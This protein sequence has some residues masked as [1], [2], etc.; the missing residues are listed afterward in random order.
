M[1]WVQ[2]RC[3]LHSVLYNVSGN[4]VL[5]QLVQ[6]QHGKGMLPKFWGWDCMYGLL[7]CHGW[8][9]TNQTHLFIL[10]PIWQ[11]QIGTN[12]ILFT[13]FSQLS[14]WHQHL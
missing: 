9:A 1:M 6:H 2:V 5:K 4:Y 13:G 10:K 11:G 7:V 12:I 8:Q 14:L 3:I